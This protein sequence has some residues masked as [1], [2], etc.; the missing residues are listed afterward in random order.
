[1]DSFAKAKCEL[2]VEEPVR[3]ENGLFT[4]ISFMLLTPQAK[5]WIDEEID[6]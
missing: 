1:M 4:V 3:M 6:A 5:W 2:H